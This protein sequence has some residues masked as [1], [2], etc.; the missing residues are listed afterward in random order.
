MMLPITTVSAPAT[1]VM[2][3]ALSKLQLDQN[4]LRD[5]Y[6][7]SIRIIAFASFPVMA[8]LIITADDVIA[9]IYGNKWSNAVP[10]FRLLCVAGLWQGIY[11]ATGQ[12]FISAGRTDRMF[13]AGFITSIILVASFLLGIHWKGKGVA[14]AYAISLSIILL[15]YLAYTYATIGL[16]LRQALGQMIAS[17]GAAITIIPGIWLLKVLLPSPMNPFLRLGI[18]VP[19]GAT[20][21]SL[22]LLILSPSLIK[23]IIHL[24]MIQFFPKSALKSSGA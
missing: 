6:T 9:V 7:K 14:L 2:V 1:N 12:V 10:I 21:F 8:G 23:E 24:V 22:V 15:P 18:C 16:S 11:N 19:I 17:F 13:K 20:I 3:P 4:R 5:A